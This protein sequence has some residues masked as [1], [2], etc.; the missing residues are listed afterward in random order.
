MGA[1]DYLIK[2]GW[3]K[4]DAEKYIEAQERGMSSKEALESV[5]AQA[6]S[7]EP[8]VEQKFEQK[9]RSD[10]EYAA[11]VDVEQKLKEAKSKAVELGKE[12]KE[13]ISAI[14]GLAPRG[15]TLKTAAG[16]L[17]LAMKPKPKTKDEI[18]REQEIAEAQ[19][20]GRLKRIYKEASQPRMSGFNVA[21]PQRVTV[22]RVMKPPR[23][24]DLPEGDMGMSFGTFGDPVGRI[25]GGTGDP[26]GFRLYERKPVGRIE[27]KEPKTRIPR[28]ERNPVVHVQ[29]VYD[30][31]GNIV[32]VGGSPLGN[33]QSGGR[34][35]I[36]VNLGA[37]RSPVNVGVVRTS[38]RIPQQNKPKTKTQKPKIETKVTVQKQFWEL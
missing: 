37:V 32:N 18:R 20:K 2:Q 29:Q 8:K 9:T 3:S 1:T 23:H 34:S 22:K 35:P 31:V 26:V 10:E 36:N 38:T 28:T 24:T 30:P 19:H 5:K 33:I 17:I 14:A 4:E 6:Q 21:R 12:A 25:P 15:K 11:Y 16:A 7:T 27:S 13:H